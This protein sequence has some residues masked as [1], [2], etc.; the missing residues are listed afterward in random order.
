MN[1]R[2]ASIWVYDDESRDVVPPFLVGE[3][4]GSLSI[5]EDRKQLRQFAESILEWL[6]RTERD[7]GATV[8]RLP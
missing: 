2:S 1:T 8:Y 6:A 3:V 4:A 7:G 5:D